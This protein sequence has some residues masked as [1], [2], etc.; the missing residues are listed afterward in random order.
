MMIISIPMLIGILAFHTIFGMTLV[1]LFIG[2]RYKL[3]QTLLA[4][5]G[6]CAAVI[7]ILGIL[8][9]R[10]DSTQLIALYSL[11]V[12]IPTFLMFWVLSPKRNWQMVFQFF[13][14]ILFCMLVQQCGG[15]MLIIV[16]KI[17]ALWLGFGLCS[18]CVL[19]VAVRYLV[20]LSQQTFQYV[21]K[22]WW[23]MC[24]LMAGYYI[25]MIYCIPDYSGVTAQATLI[26]FALTVFM[27]GVYVVFLTFIA[28]TYREKETRHQAELSEM[29]LSALQ[30]R[31]Q[32]VQETEQAVRLERHDLRH[33]LNTIA[34]LIE[35]RQ[36]EEALAVIEASE[37]RLSAQKMVSWCQSAVLDAVF[38]VYFAEA[39]RQQIQVEA[40]IRLSDQLPVEESELALV[41]ANALENAI[42]ACL[43]VPVE[44]RRIQ[45]TVIAHP[46]LMFQI[47][48]AVAAPVPLNA[49]GYPCSVQRNGH[50]WGVR[51]IL[52]FCEKYGASCRYEQQ[53]GW[54]V[55]RVIF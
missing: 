8:A 28:T 19:W 20:P 53:Q 4:V 25:I 13:T 44:R 23:L 17:W 18:A 29:Q 26:K 12:H 22:G 31:M 30:A 9:W 2:S 10:I 16:G 47:G 24:L 15:L 39:E 34:A 54:L 32:A 41:V 40:E 48:N 43:Q 11:L 33:R 3:W 6:C 37:E 38:R 51:S 36:C 14:A 55:L 50:G 27:I 46:R 21:N 1:L 52:N 7:A 5:Y 49:Q 42:N 45:C 35:E